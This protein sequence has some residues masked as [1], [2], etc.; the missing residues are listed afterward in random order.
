MNPTL[1]PLN[2]D[3]QRVHQWRNRLHTWIMVSGSALLMALIAYSVFG[4][5]GVVWAVVLTAFGLWQ[6]GR[7]SPRMVL[8]LYKARALTSEEVPQLHQLMREL[9][10]RADLPAV[11]QLYYVPSQMMNAFAVGKIDDS[12]V[13][14]TDGL[15]RNL[16]LRQLAG[17]LAHEVSHI[18]NEDLTVMALG[19][20]LSRL[21]GTLSTIGLLVGI[22]AALLTNGGVVPWVT[23]AALVA[24]PTVGGL[25]QLALSRT[26]EYDADLDAA[27]LTGDPEGLASALQ[28]LEQKQGS[29]WEKLVLPGS[30]SPEPSLLRSHPKTPDRVRRLLSLRP[31]TP[32]II[33]RPDRPMRPARSIVP[34]VRRPRINM[35]R[36]GLWY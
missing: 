32:P 11:P 6:A 15:I 4:A 9:T 19:D 12:A 10:R 8:K 28:T 18:R 25:L 36:M 30:R 35:G 23:I 1:Q 17:V 7:V 5:S 33:A 14:V 2:P 16:T 21:T 24:A 27:G 29:M 20:V 31:T 34:P 26:R 3:A 22:P 13:A